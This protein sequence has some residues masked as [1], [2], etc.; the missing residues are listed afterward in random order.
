M[1]IKRASYVG[2]PG[3]PKCCDAQIRTKI[4]YKW[5]L[6]TPLILITMVGMMVDLVGKM[7][8]SFEKTPVNLKEY[9]GAA[10]P[11]GPESLD[12]DNIG[13]KFQFKM[14]RRW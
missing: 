12:D 13:L 1:V 11:N 7:K 3:F 9:S 6:T 14:L 2:E 5:I 8:E 4:I 10:I